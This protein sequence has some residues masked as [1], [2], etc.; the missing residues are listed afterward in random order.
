MLASIPNLGKFNF[1]RGWKLDGCFGVV[2]GTPQTLLPLNPIRQTENLLR[3][4]RILLWKQLWMDCGR[5]VFLGVVLPRRLG[6]KSV[7]PLVQGLRGVHFF[8]F[9]LRV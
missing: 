1:S 4:L 7:C 3:Y 5:R 9:G 8:E 6:D 2:D